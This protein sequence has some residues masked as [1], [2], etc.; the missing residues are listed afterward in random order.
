MRIY[1]GDVSA[2]VHIGDEAIEHVWVGLE[3]QGVYSM[4]RVF[5][6]SS[7]ELKAKRALHVLPS[8][9]REVES[10]YSRSWRISSSGRKENLPLEWRMLCDEVYAFPAGLTPRG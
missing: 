4:N 1:G 8:L 9:S 5:Q 7:T 10:R 3:M 2:S 6:R